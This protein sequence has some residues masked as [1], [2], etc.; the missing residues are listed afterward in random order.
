MASIKT[1]AAPVGDR[2][3]W[4]VASFAAGT[5]AVIVLGPL[6]LALVLVTT[7]FTPATASAAGSGQNCVTSG[8]VTTGASTASVGSLDPEQ[9]HNA[10]VII[11]VAK[12]HQVPEY[13]WVVA[14]AAA[15][16]ESSL[17]NY[18]GGDADSAGLFQQRPS[19]GWGTHAQV[20]TPV[21]ATEAFFGVASYTHNTGLL[22]LR[23]WESMPVT[24]AAQ[25]V[26]KSLYPD[27]Y[28]D[29]E[30]MAR[31]LVAKLAGVHLE[32]AGPLMCGNGTAM[33]CPPTDSPGERGLTPDALRVLRCVQQQF[34]DHTYL[35]VGPR[36]NNPNSD[37]PS[38]RAV[39]IMIAR[40]QTPSG[41]AEGWRIAHW[42]KSHAPQLGV[43]YV[44]FD[45]KIWSTDRSGEGWRP[46][47]HPSGLSSP[48][49][50]HLNHVHVS[51]FG[52][53]ASDDSA[54][55]K[56]VLPVRPGTYQ[57]TARFGD[58]STLWSACHTGLDFATY[59]GAGVAIHAVTDGT[60]VSM[61]PYCGSPSSCPYGNVTVMR[62]S[63]TTTLMYAHQIRFA[64]GIHA[65]SH[66]HADEVIGYVGSTG[67]TTGPHLHLE[68]RVNDQPIDPEPWLQGHGLSP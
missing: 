3:L 46:Y 68:V 26:Q 7:V 37:H 24:V 42:V 61:T 8:F 63:P 39:D 35:G 48:T 33:D 47:T 22:D 67:N 29:N 2:R 16:Q 27:A 19:Q 59:A 45:A 31:S 58:C 25:T 36:S 40:W 52:N 57:L 32:P 11:S 13:G 44:I 34:G 18:P 60:I 6:L 5:V 20:T 51:V 1:L 21:L 9:V 10:A 4:F 28:A 41:R 12:Q 62:I 65:G 43:K 15:L 53:A 50:D 54:S 66:V 55:G 23:G 49:L 64:T 56:Y 17:H 38:G 30:A 14:L